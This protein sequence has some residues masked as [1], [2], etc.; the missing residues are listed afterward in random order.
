MAVGN[1]ELIHIDNLINYNENPRHRSTSS[2]AETIKE[3]FTCVG[4]PQMINLAEDIQEHGLIE[5]QQIVVVYSEIKKKYVVYEGNRRV[6]AIKLLLNPHSSMFDFLDE[7]YIKR[8]ETKTKG[9]T[10][11]KL[12]CYVTT[13]TEA[14]FIMQRIHSG[15][16]EGR[17][18]KKWASFEQ[19]AFKKLI[20]K[21]ARLE[22]AYLIYERISDINE[23]IDFTTIQ[24]VF[25]NKKVK[26]LI[27]LDPNDLETFT[28]E[29]MNLVLEASKWMKAEAEREEIGISRLFNRKV[30]I[31]EKLLP[32]IEEYQKEHQLVPLR[33]D[34]KEEQNESA[35]ESSS[36]EENQT[37]SKKESES[38][39][40]TKE[41]NSMKK[42]KKDLSTPYFF[43]GLQYSSL[44]I[45]DSDAFGLIR[46]CKEITDFS[47]K[48][49]IDKYPL[50]A[51]FLTRALIEQS[52]IYYS[53]K[54]YIQGQSRK[55]IEVLLKENN[56]E[57]PKLSV[58]IEKFKKN[59]SNYII[60]AN[61]KEYF[62]SNFGDYNNK[63]GRLNWTIH[64]TDQFQIQPET[65]LYLPHEGLLALINFFIK[66]ENI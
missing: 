6:A 23:Y 1:F 17:G 35:F 14:F 42:R 48:K 3:L 50:S 21:D 31:E 19:E 22:M 5:S 36:I 10:P 46:I 49:L 58:I 64:R 44:L 13:E 40:E 32:W 2:E 57:V 11:Q 30:M 62:L 66:G 33:T 53:K 38:S 8:I 18:T 51:S 45:D 43:E 20:G 54:A 61:M 39:L 52:I 25:N 9:K 15:E 56:G 7:K 60:N 41:T 16:D 28:E 55:I 34:D 59:L 4:I 47:K 12:R 37:K 29:K 26:E 24:R 27:G 65:L 63:C